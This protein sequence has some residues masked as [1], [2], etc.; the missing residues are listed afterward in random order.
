MSKISWVS[1]LCLAF[2]GF[3]ISDT[4]ASSPEPVNRPV[5]RFSR[6]DELDRKASLVVAPEHDYQSDV[7][8]LIAL[9]SHPL[10]E[11][12]ALANQL[13]TKWRRLDWN[14]YA[15]VM[16][17]VCSEI[18]NRGLNDLRVREQTQHFA[19][20]ALS[21]S[22]Q[23]L[24]EYHSSLVGWFGQRW[25]ATDSAWLRER[26]E[27]T[28]L[29]LQAWRRLYKE[30]DPSFEADFRDRKNLPSMQ[31][32]PPFET[33][34]PAGAPPSAIKDARLRARYEAAIAENKRKSQRVEQQ[35]PLLLHGPS[36]SARA[37]HWLI[38]AYSQPPARREELRRYLNI[39][40][41]DEITRRRIMNEVDKASK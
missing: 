7:H 33:G 31:V 32:A 8:Q 38:Q 12:I 36:F 29:W 14:Q 1:I 23:F 5:S 11:L 26:R 9:R 27:N 35:L 24:W 39:Y 37:E 20:V 17:Y 16:I 34:L 40:V 10:D 25:S 13:E 18:A 22:R 2:V 28:E 15:Q 4:S 30:K 6:A 19:L 3:V 41:P 21:H